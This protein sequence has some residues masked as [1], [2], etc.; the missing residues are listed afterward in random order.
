MPSSSAVKQGTSRQVSG[1]VFV[2]GCR[3]GHCFG[4][5]QEGL[6]FWQAGIGGVSGKQAGGHTGR[7]LHQQ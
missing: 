2:L 5:L 7:R 4:R 6:V 1:S 3:R